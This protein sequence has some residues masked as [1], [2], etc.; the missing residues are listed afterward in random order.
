VQYIRESENKVSQMF[1]DSLSGG[2][3]PFIYCRC[4]KHH[5]AEGYEEFA[6]ESFLGFDSW[7]GPTIEYIH[8]YG[9]AYVVDCEGCMTEL[10]KYERFIWDYRNDI[11]CYLKTR[12]DQELAWAEQEKLRNILIE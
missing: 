6:K 8:F 3:G 12:V 1:I 10:V 2:A 7:N 5:V 4:G 9:G 11:R